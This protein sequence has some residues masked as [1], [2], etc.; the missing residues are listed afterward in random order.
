MGL[1]NWLKNR[2]DKR[3]KRRH[4]IVHAIVHARQHYK[5]A[6]W[7]RKVSLVYYIVGTLFFLVLGSAIVMISLFV[8]L[9]IPNEIITASAVS[10]V[11]STVFYLITRIGEFA[12]KDIH[13]RSS[14]QFGSWFL[15]FIISCLFFGW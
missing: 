11:M 13:Y 12:S 14:E 7:M 8:Y 2:H 9:N 3:K 4:N 5:W 1:K 10:S 15:S 6:Q